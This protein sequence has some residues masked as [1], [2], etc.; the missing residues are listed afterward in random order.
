MDECRTAL[1]VVLDQVD[2]TKGACR[3]NEMVGAVLPVM[4]IDGARAAIN[5]ETGRTVA[6]GEPSAAQQL[7]AAIALVRQLSVKYPAPWVGMTFEQ[8]LDNIEQQAA[9]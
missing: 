8:R 1:S 2:Y 9:M 5:I 4:I 3:P 7:Q 6:A